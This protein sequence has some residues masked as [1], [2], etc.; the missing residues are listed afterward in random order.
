MISNPFYGCILVAQDLVEHGSS[1]ELWDLF[2]LLPLYLYGL[3]YVPLYPNNPI[4]FLLD[5]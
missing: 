1:I 2:L 4:A 3:L 5:I